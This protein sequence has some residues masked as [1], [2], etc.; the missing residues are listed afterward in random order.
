MRSAPVLLVLCAV[1]CS[2]AGSGG[3]G[4][5]SSATNPSART[6]S[7]APASASATTATTATTS[8]VCRLLDP[9]TVAAALGG[10]ASKAADT[11]T[12]CSYYRPIAAGARLFLVQVSPP[13]PAFDGPA[14]KQAMAQKDRAGVIVTHKRIGRGAVIAFR[15]DF[16]GATAFPAKGG[17]CSISFGPP[18]KPWMK[19]VADRA[20]LAAILTDVLT[21]CVA[22]FD[23]GTL[24]PVLP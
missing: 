16:A 24:T 22:A 19:A 7:S 2:T 17:V 12:S 23:S 1:G 3:A 4:G 13:D 21:R 14:F 18:E 15:A 11:G 10:R 9:A 5:P 20:P 8:A 6:G